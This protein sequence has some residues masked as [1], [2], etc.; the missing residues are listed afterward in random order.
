MMSIILLVCIVVLLLSPLFVSAKINCAPPPTTAADRPRSAKLGALV[1]RYDP[2]RD[3]KREHRI[4]LIGAIA[5]GA[6]VCF[7]SASFIYIR[8]PEWR[9]FFRDLNQCLANELHGWWC[10]S[11]FDRNLEDV[12]WIVFWTLFGGVVGGSAVYITQL[13]R[14]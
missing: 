6:F 3:W 7:V 13:L 2:T 10:G 8:G 1:A 4:A 12:F 11:S 14:K 5:L 9:W